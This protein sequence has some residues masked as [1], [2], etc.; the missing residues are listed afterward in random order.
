MVATSKGSVRKEAAPKRFKELGIEKPFRGPGRRRGV[1]RA[2]YLALSR[3][4]RAGLFTWK[5]LEAAGI[6][7]PSARDS[8][9]SRMVDAIMAKRSKR[10]LP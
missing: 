6:V 9:Y 4:V 3:K 1:T 5:E 8:D 10:Q 2:Q 7:L